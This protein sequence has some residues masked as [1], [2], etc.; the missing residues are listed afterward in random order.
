MFEEE[1]SPLDSPLFNL[2]SVVVSSHVA[3]VTLEAN[4]HTGL[5]VVSEMLRVLRGERPRGAGEFRRLA[6]ARPAIDRRLPPRHPAAPVPAHHAASKPGLPAPRL[7]QHNRE[8]LTTLL[9]YSGVEIEALG[10][11]GVLHAEPE[12][13]AR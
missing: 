1:P 13:G 12:A 11:D 4:R 8:I 9:G 10:A 6:A 5:T 2:P 3:G 7:G